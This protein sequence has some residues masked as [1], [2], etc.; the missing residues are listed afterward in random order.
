MTALDDA[1]LSRWNR[2]VLNTLT[3]DERKEMSEAGYLC[4]CQGSDPIY[5]KHY[6]EPPFSCARCGHTRCSAYRP[7]IDTRIILDLIAQLR[8]ARKD[9][10]RVS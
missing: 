9:A 5:H 7:L 2:A 6:H 4:T 10:V 1:T 3:D 8:K